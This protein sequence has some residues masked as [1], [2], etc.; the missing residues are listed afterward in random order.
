MIYG[1]D[2]YASP[3]AMGI[4]NVGFAIENDKAVQ[5]A[6]M[7]EIERRWDKIK[8]AYKNFQINTKTFER[9]L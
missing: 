9:S 4:N 6:C 8:T 3:T 7:Q 1:E 2:V 5:K